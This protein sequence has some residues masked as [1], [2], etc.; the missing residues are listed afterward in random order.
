[1]MNILHSETKRNANGFFINKY[2]QYQQTEKCSEHFF[3]QIQ[4]KVIE[5]L[6]SKRTR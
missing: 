1:M 6:I 3:D 2:D 4:K 5:C